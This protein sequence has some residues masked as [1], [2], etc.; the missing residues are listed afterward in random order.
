MNNLYHYNLSKLFNLTETSELYIS[1]NN[2]LDINTSYFNYFF[3]KTNNLEQIKNIILIL[4]TSF[5]NYVN[6]L[7][8]KK[9]NYKEEDFNEQKANVISYLEKCLESLDFFINIYENEEKVL[10]IKL[11][12]KLKS[13]I[14]NIKKNK[15]EIKTLK[16]NINLYN[17]NSDSIITIDNIREPR[18]PREPRDPREPRR[19]PREKSNIF[20]NIYEYII[21]KFL[22]LLNIFK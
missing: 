6:I 14:E 2:I 3:K 17:F 21:S 10:L 13:S 18:E 9:N 1:N 8:L 11:K 7:D 20:K 4:N 15:Y 19:E 12:T 5:Y 16:E 22:Q